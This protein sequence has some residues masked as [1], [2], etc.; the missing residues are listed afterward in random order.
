MNGFSGAGLA[1]ATPQRR[2]LSPPREAVHVTFHVMERRW[3][4]MR[5]AH[6]PTVGGGRSPTVEDTSGRIPNPQTAG[7]AWRRVA[8]ELSQRV[9]R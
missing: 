3:R 4:R 9:S 7:F 5:P 8:A 2:L 1:N 6:R